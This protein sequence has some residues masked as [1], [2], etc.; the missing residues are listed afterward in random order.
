[1]NPERADLPLSADHA[2]ARMHLDGPVAGTAP[3]TALAGVQIER[4][5]LQDYAPLDRSLEHL[6]SQL[7]WSQA[8]VAAFSVDRVPHAVTSGGNLSQAAA[9]LFYAH[10]AETNPAGTLEI[11]ELGAGIGLFARHFLD[12]FQDTCRSNGRDFYHRLMYHVTDASARMVEHWDAVGQFAEHRDRV[13]MAVTDATNPVPRESTHQLNHLRAIFCNYVFD[14]LPTTVVRKSEKGIEELRIRTWLE[15]DG[16]AAARR[17]GIEPSQF[18]NQ[19]ASNAGT[20]VD[21]LRVIAPYFDLETAFVACEANAPPYAAEALALLPDDGGVLLNHGALA[22]VER[23]VDLLAS[24]GLLLINDFGP[25]ASS[26]LDP[27]FTFQRFGATSA[28]G[29]NFPLLERF[30][31]ARSIEVHAPPGDDRRPLR[32][33]L[34]HRGAFGD[35]LQTLNREFSAEAHEKTSVPIENARR[36]L[37][38]GRKDQAL[39]DYR[40]GL[41]HSPADWLIVGEVAE[42]VGLHVLDVRAGLDLATRAVRLNPWYSPWLWN[43]LGDCLLWLQRYGDAHEAYLQARRINPADA[44]TNLNLAATLAHQG[45][46]GDALDRISRGL[47]ADGDGLFRDRLLQKQQQILSAFTGQTALLRDKSIRRAE[48]LGNP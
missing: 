1:M 41:Q 24:D 43:V 15:T 9:R 45:Q 30:C 33:R 20:N 11:L 47:A 28:I 4:T 36:H 42:F 26:A 12:A 8:G 17:V 48:R 2:F 18:A 13:R 29:V 16:I 31:D 22:C 21:A 23:A 27:A 3:D 40:L 5:M 7:A 34:V 6:I 10:C 46:L 39:A 44:R 14:A 35:T 25:A 37:A 38:A 19:L 32:T